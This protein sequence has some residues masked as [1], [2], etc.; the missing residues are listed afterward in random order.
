MVIKKI[1]TKIW[2]FEL[3]SHRF[4]ASF[5]QTYILRTLNKHTFNEN[6]GFLLVQLRFLKYFGHFR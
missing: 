6:I 2:K 3:N 5:A 1:K 4:A